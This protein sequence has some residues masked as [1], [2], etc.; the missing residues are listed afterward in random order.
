MK[1]VLSACLILLLACPVMAWDDD[2]GYEIRS[3]KTDHWQGDGYNEP[4]SPSNPYVMERDGE[5]YEIRSKRPDRWPGD[6]YN[7]PGSPSNPWI[8]QKKR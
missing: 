3:K 1:Y 4:G 2:E 6:G 5:T 8:I 7:E